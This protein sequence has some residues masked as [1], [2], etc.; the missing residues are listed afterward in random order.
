GSLAG[1]VAITA[2]A[3]LMSP[4]KSAVIGVVGA[5]VMHAVTLLLIRLR[6]DDAVDAVPVHLG[7]GVWGTLAVGLLG[8]QDAFPTGAS[9]IEQI[10]IQLVGIGTCFLWAFGL[11]FVV[12]SLINRRF[13]FRI[14]AAGELAGLNIAEH[15]ATTEI[16]DLLADMDEHHRTG[17]FA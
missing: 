6:I 13:P 11:G 1:L 16:A 8:D 15:G 17:D 12:L 2:S 4:W 5:V 7:A 10:G 9:R 14:D 3:Y